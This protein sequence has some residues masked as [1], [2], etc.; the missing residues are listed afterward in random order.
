MGCGQGETPMRLLAVG[1][2]EDF[3]LMNKEVGQ[4]FVVNNFLPGNDTQRIAAVKI[5]LACPDI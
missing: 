3:L 4:A 5:I 1:C 2:Q